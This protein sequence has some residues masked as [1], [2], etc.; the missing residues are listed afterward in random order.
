MIKGVLIRKA[1]VSDL[2][3]LQQMSAELIDSDNRFNE[4]RMLREWSLGEEGKKYLLRRIRGKKGICLVAE[5][6]GNIVG[7]ITGGESEI[8]KWRPFRR[9]EIDNLFVR[10][11]YRNQRIGSILMDAF[12]TWAKSRGIEKVFLHVMAGN[13]ESIRFY[14]N[15]FFKKFNFVLEKDI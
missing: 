9:I 8:Q 1:S 5:V 7:Y 12:I 13:Q 11:S 4:A 6:E 15:K 10:Q 14:E 3:V 2:S